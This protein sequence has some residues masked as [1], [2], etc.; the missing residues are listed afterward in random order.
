MDQGQT[1]SIISIWEFFVG[2][3][4]WQEDSKSIRDEEKHRTN[5]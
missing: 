5:N 3:L 1:E 2:F 4:R